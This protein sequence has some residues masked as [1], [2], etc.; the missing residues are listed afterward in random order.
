MEIRLELPDWVEPRRILILAGVELVASKLPDEEWKIKDNRCN[1]CGQ[2]C[3]NLSDAGGRGGF[4]AVKNGICKYL[5]LEPGTTDKY[6]CGIVTNKP[7]SCV[8]DP[9][10]D[11]NCNITYK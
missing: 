2:C 8:H 11:L 1:R 6:Y 5:K 7:F 4:P 10:N 3:K 9:V